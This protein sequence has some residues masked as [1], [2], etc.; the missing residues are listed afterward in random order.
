MTRQRRTDRC[1]NS[2]RKSGIKEQ[3]KEQ[4]DRGYQEKYDE[5]IKLGIGKG[6]RE[7]QLTHRVREIETRIGKNIQVQVG[8]ELFVHFIEI[9][10]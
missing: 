8:I 4:V 6:K 5:D 2:K 1:N 10:F 3:A 7:I 9:E